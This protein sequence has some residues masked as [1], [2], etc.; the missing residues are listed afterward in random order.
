MNGDEWILGRVRECLEDAL[1]LFASYLFPADYTGGC[2]GGVNLNA[3]SPGCSPEEALRDR[4][5]IGA[6]LTLLCR[7]GEA[8][9]EVGLRLGGGGA[10]GKGD[11]AEVPNSTVTVR[12][13]V[14]SMAGPAYAFDAALTVRE[15][16]EEGRKSG[17]WGGASRT[18]HWILPPPLAEPLEKPPHAGFGPTSWTGYWTVVRARDW[19]CWH[20]CAFRP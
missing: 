7:E 6:M 15:A 10:A 3:D 11:G 1:G 4:A 19:R 17:P 2:G 14:A 13:R 5:V 20:C 9:V 12:H 18:G 8:E 16:L